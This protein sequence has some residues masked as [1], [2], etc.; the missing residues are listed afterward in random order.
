MWP[1]TAVAV[2][3]LGAR[4]VVAAGRRRHQE[5][6]KHSLSKEPRRH[7]FYVIHHIFAMTGLAKERSGMLR[8]PAEEETTW[9]MIKRSLGSR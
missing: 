1:A 3:A 8:C 2:T 7:D 4:R 6:R 5:H 9:Q